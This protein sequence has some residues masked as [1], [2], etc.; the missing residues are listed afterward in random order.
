MKGKNVENEETNEYSFLKDS[1]AREEREEEE[2]PTMKAKA[3]EDE[4][5]NG[6]NV[7]K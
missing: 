6:S 4:E 1:T 5:A 7:S 2:T 3:V